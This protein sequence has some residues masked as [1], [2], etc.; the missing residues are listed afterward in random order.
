VLGRVWQRVEPRKW[1]DQEVLP[2]STGTAKIKNFVVLCWP[3]DIDNTAL[4][5]ISFLQRGK[6]SIIICLVWQLEGSSPLSRL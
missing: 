5:Y 6:S 4:R 3:Q 1:L 2:T